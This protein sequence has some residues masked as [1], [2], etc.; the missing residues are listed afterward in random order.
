MLGRSTQPLSARQLDS[1]PQSRVLIISTPDDHI[2]ET[3]KAIANL[4]ANPTRGRTILHT[5][6]ALSSADVLAPLAEKGFHTGSLHPLVSVSEPLTGADK[7]IGAFYCVEGDAAASRVARTIVRQLHGSSF[8]IASRDKP[9]YHAAAVTASGHMVALFSVATDMLTRAGLNQKTARKVLLSLLKSTVANLSASDPAN[10]L[11]GTFARGDL[12][13]VRRH[14]RALSGKEFTEA[15]AA[16]KL[17]GRRSLELAK[18]AIDTNL[19]AQ[20]QR[21]LD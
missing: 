18:D 8:H 3:A 12:D 4:P 2:L 21:E 10:A 6:G 13:T 19:R 14:L 9:L 7:L 20:I 5:S 17:L 16:Y 1:L 15:L 11:T